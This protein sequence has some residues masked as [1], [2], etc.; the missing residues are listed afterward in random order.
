MDRP[1]RRRQP[2]LARADGLEP[3]PHGRRQ[4]VADPG[5]AGRGP[6]LA[7]PVVGGGCGEVAPH[8]PALALTVEVVEEPLGAGRPLAVGVAVQAAGGGRHP[9]DRR[10]DPVAP[11]RCPGRARGRVDALGQPFRQRAEPGHEVGAGLGRQRRPERLGGDAE[12]LGGPQQ[13][14]R[15]RRRPRLAERVGLGPERVEVARQGLVGPPQE[16]GVAGERGTRGRRLGGARLRPV[17]DLRGHAR[18]RLGRRYPVGARRGGA[19]EPERLEVDLGERVLERARRRALG[20]GRHGSG[21]A[22]RRGPV[23]LAADGPEHDGVRVQA[24]RRKAAAR[25]ERGRRLLVVLGPPSAGRRR[26]DG[27][28]AWGRRRAP[29]G[30]G[31][32]VVVLGQVRGRRR[33]QER[34]VGRR[35]REQLQQ[36]RHVG[37]AAGLRRQL[38]RHPVAPGGRARRRAGAL[39][40]RRRRRRAG[41]DGGLGGPLRGGPLGRTAGRGGRLALEHAQSD[42]PEALAP[43]AHACH[44]HARLGGDGVGAEPARVEQDDA[45]T[46][47]ELEV[48]GGRRPLE[49]LDLVGQQQD[50]LRE[51]PRRAEQGPGERGPL[52]PVEPG[53]PERRRQLGEGVAAAG[54]DLDLARHDALAGHL[55]DDDVERQ[56][57][58]GL[59][60]V[61]D[62]GR[63]V[64]AEREQREQRGLSRGPA[65][66]VEERAR[67]QG[68]RGVRRAVGEVLVVRG[69]G[70]QSALDGPEARRPPAVLLADPEGE[71]AP[72]EVARVR[73]VVPVGDAG[74][75][76]RLQA[77]PA[78]L[79]GLDE[80]RERPGT[81]GDEGGRGHGGD[82]HPP[83][84]TPPGPSAPAVWITG[85]RS[86]TVPPCLA[87]AIGRR[88]RPG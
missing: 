78:D 30:L 12:S 18:V 8:E 43:V 49:R 54:L 65:H 44:A 22:N 59:G 24:R 42:L 31:R 16:R 68:Q 47:A 52:G 50:R 57:G 2:R 51:Q 32:R 19:V 55:V 77:Q 26:R 79:G 1:V 4:D 84:H 7:D 13:A 70:R 45:G 38:G 69:V 14:T 23:P 46:A 36:L 76:Q 61:G 74:Q 87:D 64:L 85:R 66:G 40:L 5:R 39:R 56:D 41:L 9:V 37:D 82:R 86:G 53:G 58:G 71:A 48:A 3:G 60:V 72:D 17:S 81:S 67:R 27:R 25:P 28:P 11:G 73:V 35:G 20:R 15:V 34:R 10:A 33:V 6:G 83:Q 63:P 21:R 62:A 80:R 29:A 75:R 88:P